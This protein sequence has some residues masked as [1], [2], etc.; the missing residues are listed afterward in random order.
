[1]R[2]TITTVRD[3]RNWV[4]SAT[5]GWWERTDEMVDELTE[6]ICSMNHPAYGTDWSAW[7][8][9]LPELTEFITA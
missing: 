4:D 7:L 2:Y 8:A 1:M 3:L 9:D 5:D 6:S